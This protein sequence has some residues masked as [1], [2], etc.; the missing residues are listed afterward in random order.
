ML[1]R[2]LFLACVIMIM[3]TVLA[4]VFGRGQ[5]AGGAASTGYTP[6]PPPEG[7]P[8]KGFT[9][10]AKPVT[11]HFAQSVD[12]TDKTLPAGDAIDNSQFTRFMTQNFNVNFKADWTAASGDDYNQ[13]VTLAIASNNLPDA[14]VVNQ[15]QFLKAYQAGQLKDITGLWKANVSED[16]NYYATPQVLAQAT[17]DGKLWAI[18]GAQVGDDGIHVMM[19]RKDWLDKLRLPV[20]RTVED[21]H[22]T[23]KAFIDAGLAKVGITGPAKGGKVSANF[24]E[25]GTNM[26]GFDFLFQA[27]DAWPGYWLLDQAG[28]VQYGTNTPETRRA[29]STLAAWFKE[30]LLDPEIGV[31]QDSSEL[32]NS[33]QAG[34]FNGS[35]WT[36]GYGTTSA[37]KNDPSMDWQ[38]YPIYDDKGKWNL[39]Y[40]VLGNSYLIINKKASD[41][42]VKA[43][44]TNKN[45]YLRYETIFDIAVNVNWYPLRHLIND[46]TLGTIEYDLYRD[47][48]EGT[49]KREDYNIPTSPNPAYK[50][51][52]TNWDTVVQNTL[53]AAP[54]YVKGTP[55]GQPYPISWWNQNGQSFPRTYSIVNGDRAFITM[56]PD[57]KVFSLVYGVATDTLERRYQNLKA[58]EDEMFFRIITGQESISYFD[59]FVSRW[60]AEGGD[61]ITAE[62]QALPRN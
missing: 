45:V 19:I 39:H 40:P 49:A 58:L 15:S 20:P 28:K 51:Y 46:T 34:I 44:I 22:K 33:G 25:S 37:W 10:F 18:P 27:M 38:G 30:G 17:F 53:E 55:R 24:F 31:R 61:Q 12:P 57:K 7:F 62:I 14:M 47:I 56:Q 32:I 54:G 13:K 3:T 59:T 48:L 9:K 43:I 5:G 29:L 26:H 41:D 36:I 16:T 6:P 11:I 1:K 50:Y 35:W 52:Y 2:N 8:A 42:V 21:V 4:P 23:A 60:K